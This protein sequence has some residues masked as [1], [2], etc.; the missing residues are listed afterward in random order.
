[1]NGDLS[2]IDFSS[3][4]QKEGK[5]SKLNGRIS[6]LYAENIRLIPSL[7]KYDWERFWF[8]TLKSFCQSL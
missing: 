6:F 1:M 8:E 3:L 4:F 7:S 2:W 5:G